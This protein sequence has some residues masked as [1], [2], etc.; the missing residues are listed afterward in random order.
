V[1]L[2]GTG[3][4]LE[5]AHQAAELLKEQGIAAAVVSLPCWE[6]FAAQD[7]AYQTQ[8]LGTAPRIAVEAGV[9]QGWEQWTGATGRF[10]GMSTFGASAPASA[11]Y[12]HFAITPKTVAQ[13]AKDVIA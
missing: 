8:V 6:R 1:T 12:E 13:A 4:E 9:A 5:T 10:V 7:Q 3:S 11:L 2:I